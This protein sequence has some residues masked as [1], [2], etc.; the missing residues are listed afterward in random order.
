MKDPHEVVEGAEE[1][2]K[3]SDHGQ[4]VDDEEE[5]LVRHDALVEK[6]SYKSNVYCHLVRQTE[7]ITLEE[8]SG[9]A[10]DGAVEGKEGGEQRY[11]YDL[12]YRSIEIGVVTA[13]AVPEGLAYLVKIPAGKIL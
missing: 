9:D 4:R 12:C 1:V 13:T 6:E 7:D 10:G 5:H 11:S 3:H 2:G 8:S